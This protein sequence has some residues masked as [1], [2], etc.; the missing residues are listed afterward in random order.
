MTLT[1]ERPTT[2]D[3]VVADTGGD[4]PRRGRGR[5]LVALALVLVVAAATAVL[6]WEHTGRASAADGGTSA[7]R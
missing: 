4:A 5:A 1:T 2:A 3:E 7:S 6:V